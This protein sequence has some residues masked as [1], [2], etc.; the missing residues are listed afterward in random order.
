MNDYWVRSSALVELAAWCDAFDNVLGPALAHDYA[1]AC[2]RI[3][4]E[5]NLPA[6]VEPIAEADGLTILGNWA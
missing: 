6:F 4:G 1:Y 5:L 3:A 2:V